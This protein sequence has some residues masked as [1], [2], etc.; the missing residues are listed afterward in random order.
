MANKVL[1]IDAQLQKMWDQYKVK[2]TCF[3][4]PGKEINKMRREFGQKALHLD[5]DQVYMVDEKGIRPFN[6]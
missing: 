2:P 6:G 1:E 5:D 3:I 4:I